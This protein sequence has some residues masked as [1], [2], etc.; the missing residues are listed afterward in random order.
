MSQLVFSTPNNNTISSTVWNVSG[1]SWV[2]GPTCVSWRISW[3]AFSSA[4][5]LSSTSFSLMTGQGGGFSCFWLS[6]F[7]IVAFKAS[8]SALVAS[9]SACRVS[10]KAELSLAWMQTNTALS[11]TSW[12]RRFRT[13]K[14]HITESNSFHPPPGLLS[15]AAA[16]VWP[17]CPCWAL[18]TSPLSG[19]QS[20]ISAA[21][22]SQPCGARSTAWTPPPH[23]LACTPALPTTHAL[24]PE[25]AQQPAPPP[26]VE[27]E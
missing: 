22:S 7:C 20:L 21:L 2:C 16:S 3:A 15:A 25:V 12:H 13:H 24:S 26:T 5:L 8:S 4:L 19:P 27:G 17:P 6:S 18:C 23:V 1:Y 14:G 11:M 10:L 9:R